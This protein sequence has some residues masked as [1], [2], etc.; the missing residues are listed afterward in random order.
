MEIEITVNSAGITVYYGCI[1]KYE[2]IDIHCHLRPNIHYGSRSWEESLD[3]IRI[4]VEDGIKGAVTTPHWIQ[5]TNWQSTPER[6]RSDVAELNSRIGD[7][8]RGCSLKFANLGVLHFIPSDAH[9]K[10]HRHCLMCLM[11]RD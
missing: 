2:M 4:A 8:A 3:M 7:A 1:Y 9:S 10:K 11:T 5:G 6:V